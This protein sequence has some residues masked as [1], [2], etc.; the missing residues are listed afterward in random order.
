MQVETKLEFNDVIKAE[1]YIPISDNI[2]KQLNYMSKT[3]DDFRDFFIPSK[4]KVQFD[5]CHVIKDVHDILRPQLENNSIK[6]NF[7]CDEILFYGFPNEFKQVIINILNNSKDAIVMNK[8]VDGEI[9]VEV[10]KIENNILITIKD[11]GGGIDNSIINKVFNPYF[12]TK[13]ESKGT[14]IGLYMSKMIIEKSMDGV[15]SV[16]S[17]NETTLFTIKL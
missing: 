16:E 7:I 9:N 11:N 2:N 10:K 13:F 14:G 5:V 4:T 15:L 3:I 1:E 6:F 8:I 12:T 17:I